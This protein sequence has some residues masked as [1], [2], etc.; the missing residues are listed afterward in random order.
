MHGTQQHKL[1]KINA[2]PSKR[3]FNIPM[4]PT[5][6]N[7]RYQGRNGFTQ[8]PQ[9][10]DQQQE[11]F[12]HA[13]N[14]I[15]FQSVAPPSVEEIMSKDWSKERPPPQA[16]ASTKKQIEDLKKERASVLNKLYD[17]V[18]VDYTLDQTHQKRSFN[19]LLDMEPQ[20]RKA[21]ANSLGGMPIELTDEEI[22]T[23]V[24]VKKIHSAIAT[25][26][27]PYPFCLPASPTPET[28]PSVSRVMYS[29]CKRLVALHR[30]L[31]DIEAEEEQRAYNVRRTAEERQ[32]REEE[33]KRR[34]EERFPVTHEEWKGKKP[35]YQKRIAHFFKLGEA[36]HVKD[37]RTKM[38]SV[39]D[40]CVKD[41]RWDVKSVLK[42]M[43]EYESSES[44]RS[45]I[46]VM[47][48]S[49]QTRDPRKA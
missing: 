43:R 32:R 17:L 38:T 7:P 29:Y 10:Q 16:V 23:L 24:E 37:P 33:A 39:Q 2:M 8:L 5:H 41:N 6:S 4:V 21:H 47:N 15:R 42:L 14:T 18:W 31:K 22:K 19:D 12:D 28:L 25:K 45:E 13:M 49:Q 27:K 44:F 30:Q 3:R 1:T 35:E 11:A 36:T 46:V 40:K 9:T 26:H 20:E 34:E 48:I